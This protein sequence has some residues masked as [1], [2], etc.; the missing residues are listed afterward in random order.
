MD[1]CDDANL[2]HLHTNLLNQ[3]HVFEFR[4]MVSVHF[5]VFE[6][7]TKPDS[8]SWPRRVLDV[9]DDVLDGWNRWNAICGTIVYL[10]GIGGGILQG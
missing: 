7:I 10:L 1:R 8:H 3:E 6:S 9:C 2:V 5:C 4:D